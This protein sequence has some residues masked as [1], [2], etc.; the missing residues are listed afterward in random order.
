MTIK[1]G[2]QG[3]NEKDVDSMSRVA[4]LNKVRLA[5]DTLYFTSKCIGLMTYRYDLGREVDVVIKVPTK[6]LVT[7]EDYLN[8][9]MLRVTCEVLQ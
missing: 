2:V 4:N 6:G 3:G 1:I 8:F 5:Y 9:L 7:L